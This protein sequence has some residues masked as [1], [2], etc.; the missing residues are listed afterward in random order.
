MDRQPIRWI[1]VLVALIVVAPASAE[2]PNL[3]IVASEARYRVREKLLGF[4]FPNDAVGITQ[5]VS[6]AIAF[7]PQGRPVPGS[8]IIVDLRPSG[9]YLIYT[10]LMLQDSNTW[11]I[12]MLKLTS[13]MPDTLAESSGE[14][15]SLNPLSLA[16][17][18]T[19]LDNASVIAMISQDVPHGLNPV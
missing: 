10:S 11:L 5:G 18:S 19:P 14:V 6:G 13:R 9:M 15:T 7:D 17:L 12:G 4:N 3:E 1:P 2:A 8:K 16:N